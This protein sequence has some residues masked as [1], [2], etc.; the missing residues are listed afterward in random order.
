MK[1]GIIER[2]VRQDKLA[3]N[4]GCKSHTVK[5][6]ANHTAPESCVV[7]REGCDEVLTGEAVG[8]VLSCEITI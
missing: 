7:V 1:K 5:D 6:L 8:Q 4:S 3:K 2:L